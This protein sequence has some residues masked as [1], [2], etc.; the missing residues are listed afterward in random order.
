V[1]GSHSNWSWRSEV[2]CT[3]HGLKV[4]GGE[5]AHAFFFMVGSM[6]VRLVK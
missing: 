2:G 5:F 4:D 1:A 6:M 3:L